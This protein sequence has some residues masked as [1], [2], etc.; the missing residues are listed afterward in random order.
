[1]V[2]KNENPNKEGSARSGHQRGNGDFGSGVP[3]NMLGSR[4][5]HGN[6]D[7]TIIC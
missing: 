6:S 1:M 5:N 7:S 3:N 4:G 2:Q